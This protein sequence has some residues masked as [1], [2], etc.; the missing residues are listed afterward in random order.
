MKVESV[1]EKGTEQGK[2][3]MSGLV[4]KRKLMKGGKTVR[5]ECMWRG[6]ERWV[7]CV[8]GK[9]MEEGGGNEYLM[10]LEG[11]RKQNQEWKGGGSKLE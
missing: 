7:E 11:E 9:G 6:I 5:M 1:D 2:G 10:K 3:N 4:K 8:E